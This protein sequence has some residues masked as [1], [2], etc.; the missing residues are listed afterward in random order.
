MQQLGLKSQFGIK[1]NPIPWID[2]ITSNTFA[3][4]FEATSVQYSK[5]SMVGNWVY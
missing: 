5:A 1:T 4:F 3:N 2:L